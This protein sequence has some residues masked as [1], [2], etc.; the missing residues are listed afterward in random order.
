MISFFILDHE[1]ILLWRM[2]GRVAHDALGE[3]AHLI[4]RDREFGPPRPQARRHDGN[5]RNFAQVN[6]FHP[7][8]ALVDPVQDQIGFAIQEAFARAAHRLEVQMQARARALGEELSEHAQRLRTWAEIANHHMD[9]AF[10]AHRQLGGMDAQ[11]IEL[12]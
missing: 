10:L 4:R 6:P 9:F 3:G 12:P 8:V 2:A 5:E 11:A 1:V 7:R